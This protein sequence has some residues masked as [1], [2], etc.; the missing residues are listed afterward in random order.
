MA[1]SHAHP[2]PTMSGSILRLSV[3]QRLGAALA[4]SGALWGMIW[5]AMHP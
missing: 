3:W 1:Q 5:W 2:T 4:L